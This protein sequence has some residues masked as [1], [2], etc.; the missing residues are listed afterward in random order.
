MQKRKLTVG[1]YDWAVFSGM[2]SHAFSLQV[3]PI[4]LLAVSNQLGFSLAEGGFAKGGMISVATGLATAIAT[5]SCSYLVSS[6]GKRRAFAGGLVILLLGL[7]AVSFARSYEMYVVYMMLAGVGGGIIL[8]V[9]PAV[10]HDL[11]PDDS[12]KYIAIANSFWSGGMLLTVLLTGYLLGQGFSWRSIVLLVGGVIVLPVVLIL[13]PHRDGHEFPES[14]GKASIKDVSKMKINLI[15][16]SSF[17]VF[18]IILALSV[19]AEMTISFWTASYVQLEFGATAEAGG[20]AVG[21]FAVGMIVSRFMS[22]Y[23]VRQDKIKYFIVGFAFAAALVTSIIT[24]VSSLITLYFVLIIAGLF[25]APLWP[26]LQSYGVE[27]L[28]PHNKTV[29][30][31]LLTISGTASFSLFSWFTGE[32]A[33]HYNTLRVIYYITPINY[34][35]VGLILLFKKR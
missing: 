3:M 20:F 16:D 12:G 29:V 21:C 22:G 27:R 19:G 11:H 25:I 15:K 5:F 18:I 17:W 7:I 28:R 32:L 30:L 1:R 34:T 4:I 2:F 10:A 33:S 24:F 31:V 9:A 13:L 6:F 23:F 26:F 8:G 35:L 14:N